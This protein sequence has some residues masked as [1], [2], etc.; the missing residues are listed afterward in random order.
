MLERDVELEVVNLELIH[1]VVHLL[2]DPF[3]HVI[4]RSCARLSLELK[5]R[6][7]DVFGEVPCYNHQS[8]FSVVLGD[9]LELVGHASP[10]NFRDFNVL[11]EFDV[12]VSEL[13]L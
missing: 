4:F 1:K 13:V 3:H 6:H 2:V 10:P 9:D 11:A 7:F 8:I 12:D 5:H